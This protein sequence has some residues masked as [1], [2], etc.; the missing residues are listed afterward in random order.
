MPH[1]EPIVTIKG[2]ILDVFAHRFVVETA[3][4]K[5][6]A[7]LGKHTLEKIAIKAEDEV[8]LTGEQKPSELKI[9][10]MILNG[11][12][13]ALEPKDKDHHKH[14]EMKSVDPEIAVHAAKKEHVTVIGKP[15]RKPQH[16][17]VLGK[18]PQGEL[19]ELHIEL[20]GKLRKSKPVKPDDEK[21]AQELSAA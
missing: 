8:E 16:F 17:E 6:L 5:I 10:K 15:H 14:E 18:N 12:P 3:K 21:W 2:T 11:K 19:V 4:G 1:D 7:D 13:V 20:D 9:H